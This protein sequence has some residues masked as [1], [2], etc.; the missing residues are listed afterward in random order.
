MLANDHAQRYYK[1]SY[2]ALNRITAGMSNDGNYD[3]ARNYD[4]AL[5]R[6]MNIDPMTDKR[7][8]LSPYQYVQNSPML[9]IDPDGAFDIYSL[10]KESGDINLVETN[11]DETDTLID[12]ES[13]E[14]VSENIDKGLLS[15][16]QNIM[17]DGLETS[18]V[19]GGI[20]LAVDISMHT[21]D[22]IG[23]VVYTDKVGNKMLNVLPYEHS[24][25]DLDSNGK[26]TAVNGGINFRISPE[27]TSSDGIFTGKATS[28]FHTHP[29][30]P[31]AGKDIIG[32][33]QPSGRDLELADRNA[34]VLRGG[35]SSL[36]NLKYYVF[37]AKTITKGG[38]TSNATHYRTFGRWGVMKK[39]YNEF[40][41]K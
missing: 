30:H 36:S 16:G 11:Q 28:A 10:D 13:N 23:G 29:G 25:F 22:E 18:N 17:Q 20:K 8:W 37:G 41:K 1:Y 19:K 21:K 4:E 5:G 9:R 12:S 31:N 7:E 39:S 3:G 32:S 26:V 14:T 34:S 38:N 6:W 35:H 2:D 40:L 27:F 24:T 15:D 33:P